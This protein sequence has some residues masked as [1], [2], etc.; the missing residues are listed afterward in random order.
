M[1]LILPSRFRL[2]PPGP[3]HIDWSHPLARGL[4][5]FAIGNGGAD[6]VSMSDMQRIGDGT[7]A[8]GKFGKS[9]RSNANTS[10]GW[11][12]KSDKALMRTITNAYTISAHC[13]I[14]TVAANGKI[15]CV[16][17]TNTTWVAP[18][19]AL[20]LGAVATDGR[21]FIYNHPGA[22]AGTVPTRAQFGANTMAAGSRH[23][24][25]S[26]DGATPEALINGSVSAVNTNTLTTSPIV[27]GTGDSVVHMERS[28]SSFGEGLTGQIYHSAIWN[29]ALSLDEKKEFYENPYGLLIPARNVLYSFATA[30]GIPAAG[31]NAVEGA[32]TIPM[33]VAAGEAV[34]TPIGAE[35]TGAVTIP[36]QAAA[37]EASNIGLFE[38]E[39]AATI[40]MQQATGEAAFVAAALEV[41]GAA[42]IPMQQATGTAL[43]VPDYAAA[44]AVTIPMQTLAG[45]SETRYN[46]ARRLNGTSQYFDWTTSPAGSVSNRSLGYYGWFRPEATP[47]SSGAYY[48]ADYGN[49]TSSSGGAGRV[50]LIYDLAA[51]Q[52][53]ASSASTDGSNYRE[54]R[55]SAAA[56]VVNKWYFVGVSVSSA[57]DIRLI[58]NKTKT[59]ATSGTI[60]P[61]STNICNVFRIGN[62]SKTANGGLWAGSVS[63]WTLFLGSV[64]SDDNLDLMADGYYPPNIPGL[65]PSSVWAM[66]GTSTTESDRIG[67][68]TLNAISS[69]TTVSLADSPPFYFGAGTATTPMQQAT[70]DALFLGV[71]TFT[72]AGAYTIPMQQAAGTATAETGGVRGAYTIPMQQATGAATRTIPAFTVAGAATIPMQR[73][74][75]VV[76]TGTTPGVTYYVSTITNTAATISLPDQEVRVGLGCKRGDVPNG[77]IVTAYVN[78]GAVKTQISRRRFW[79]DG[80]LKYGEASFLMPAL[81][82]GQT[83]NVEWRKFAGSWTAQDTGLHSGA[84][85]IASNLN[86]EWRAVSWINRPTPSTLGTDVGPLSFRVLDM[87]SGGNSAWIKTVSTGHLVTEWEATIFGKKS[88]GT[89]HPNFG[90]RLYVRAWGGTASQPKR[91]QFG[92]KSMYGWSDNSIPADAYGF[93]ASWD[94]L[95]G[96]TVVRGSSIGTTGWTAVQGFKGGA[97][98]SFGTS[99]QLDW[100][101]V[102][103]QTRFDPP[104]LV[105]KHSMQYLIDA[106]LLPNID[107]TNTFDNGAG[108]KNT[109][110][111]PNTKGLCYFNMADVGERDDITWGL[112]GWTARTM[113]AHGQTVTIADTAAHQQTSR[114]Q[115]L[116][117]AAIPCQG[118]RRDTRGIVSHMPASRIPDARLSPTLVGSF[119]E[120]ASGTYTGFVTLDEAHFPNLAY[121]DYLTAGNHHVLQLVYGEAGAPATFT[122]PAFGK[123]TSVILYDQPGEPTFPVAHQVIRGQIRG[124]A[125]HVLQVGLA[126]GI[127]HPDDVEHIYYSRILEDW[128]TSSSQLP[129]E[130]DRWRGGTAHVDN[131]IYRSANDP[132]YKGWMH[133]LVLHGLSAT[134]GITRRADV[135]AQADWWANFPKLAMGGYNDGA[136]ADKRVQATLY[137]SDELYYTTNFGDGGGTRSPFSIVKQWGNPATITYNANNTITVAS[138]TANHDGAVFTP[139]NSATPAAL[140]RGAKYYAVQTAGQTSFRGGT[141][142]LSTTV[143][144]AP[145]NFGIAA[146]VS[147]TAIYRSDPAVIAAALTDGLNNGQNNGFGLQIIGALKHY[148][149]NCTAD[150]IVEKAIKYIEPYKLTGGGGWVEKAKWAVIY[151]TSVQTSYQVYNGADPV[152]N[153]ADEVWSSLP[154]GTWSGDFTVPMVQAVGTLGF[155]PGLDGDTMG[156]VTIPMQVA[157]GEI[158][159][160]EV[161]FEAF[162]DFGLPMLQI[163]VTMTAEAPPSDFSGAATIPMQTASGTAAFAPIFSFGNAIIPMQT[164]SGTA[165]S[166]PPVTL[167]DGA[168]TIPMQ[169]LSG[170][171]SV[172]G[173]PIHGD[174][175]I[176]M[177][178]A[179][180]EVVVEQFSYEVEGGFIVPMITVEGEGLVNAFD[181]NGGFIIPMQT[182]DGVM[183][184]FVEG[185]VLSGDILIPMVQVTSDIDNEEFEARVSGDFVI[186]G[187]VIAGQLKS[188]T[189]QDFSGGIT[190]P[191][192]TA[193]GTLPPVWQ[194]VTRARREL[195]TVITP[196]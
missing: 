4:V 98:F 35:V 174:I 181:L 160:P 159:A 180:G 113:L 19:M 173:V 20:G 85:V 139:F 101:D 33:Q 32:A 11:Y 105:H 153:G 109:P 58:V 134:Y 73:V 76:A 66:L 163:V 29:R 53:V 59:S 152:Y 155:V 41:E 10:S 95:V 38:A 56:L 171:L 65:A 99:G 165:T 9:I 49:L 104:A 69:P 154:G 39:G 74:N 151:D 189:S 161:V 75:G 97:H 157:A 122:S 43:L 127:G 175:L 191:M 116:A 130:E 179:F 87:L 133:T 90:A 8:D 21:V 107:L 2:Q 176:P 177:V 131:S 47:G 196:A 86:A 144:G 1:A 55:A 88:D 108:K 89:F 22:G 182:A 30:T 178:Q 118:Y 13:D 115:A 3:A 93:Q 94:L 169:T 81:S 23:Y 132:I 146:P 54:A 166:T 170:E 51:Q 124:I 91:I 149:H 185:R 137:V 110:Y 112:T 193:G 82:A 42:T 184:L 79:D 162:G 28:P 36:M 145:I 194:E 57:G 100:F 117:V 84:S 186:P 111:V 114:T 140:T 83:V 80:S 18:Y 106:R 44:G 92:F 168:V 15:L 25:I 14:E 17:L 27:F 96:G 164:A 158:V 136:D 26:R 138:T 156:A 77:W 188:I 190:I 172:S 128:C 67:S 126:V 195:W 7:L 119:P 167:L 64:P 148:Y 37:G 121:F 187:I 135:L 141:L 60:T 71:G 143:G 24:I 142:K 31:N 102:Q 40:P 61:S 48:I 129:E 6:L 123:D 52:F 192:Q 62:N 147:A 125:R 16:P 45:A 70:G 46:A 120:V 50:R 12:S 5:Y 34:Y 183:E 103:T 72:A 63:T 78:G 68:R 150:P